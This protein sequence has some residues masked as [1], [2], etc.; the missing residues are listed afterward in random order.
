MDAARQPVPVGALGEITI[1]GPG[2]T[3]GYDR[4]PDTNA[5]AFVD[6]WFR[7]GDQGRFDDDGYLF[8]TGRINE[9]YQPRGL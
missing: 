9:S 2:V 4:N 1:R 7:T 5:S 3:A 6:G 8:I